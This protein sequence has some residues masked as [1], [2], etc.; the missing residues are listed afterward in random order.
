[1]THMGAWAPKPEQVGTTQLLDSP[2]AIKTF[3]DGF[4][5]QVRARLGALYEGFL[6]M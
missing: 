4:T 3:I 5:E 6:S 2:A 1:M